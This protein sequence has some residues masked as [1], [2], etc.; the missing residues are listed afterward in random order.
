MAE[1]DQ[2]QVMVLMV[3]SLAAA[4]A[5]LKPALKAAK[6]VMVKCISGG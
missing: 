2:A 3:F 5:L 1:M 6:V 4:A